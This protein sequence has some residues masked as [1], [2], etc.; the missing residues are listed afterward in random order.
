MDLNNAVFSL[1]DKKSPASF[2]WRGFFV[3]LAK[4]YLAAAAAA[5][6]SFSFAITASATLLGQGA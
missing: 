4:S 5:F 6:F 1:I 3:S 2:H